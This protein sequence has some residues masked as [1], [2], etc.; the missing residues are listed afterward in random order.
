MLPTLSEKDKKSKLLKAEDKQLFWQM[1]NLENAFHFFMNSP[2]EVEQLF[3]EYDELT[4]VGEA[5][6]ERGPLNIL[7]VLD[8]LEELSPDFAGIDVTEGVKLIRKR[9]ARSPG[10]TLE[11]CGQPFYFMRN[12]TLQTMNF[13]DFYN[14]SLMPRMKNSQL[15]AHEKN[16]AQKNQTANPGLRISGTVSS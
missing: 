12:E 3:I 5:Y 16:T 2:A 11:I 15:E 10:L 4:A 14:E 13:L 7:D 9:L 8:M 6:K 1:K